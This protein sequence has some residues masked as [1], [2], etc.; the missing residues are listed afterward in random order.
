MDPLK[1]SFLILTYADVSGTPKFTPFLKLGNND[2]K[3]SYFEIALTIQ[4]I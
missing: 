2:F 4:L 1:S 3:F